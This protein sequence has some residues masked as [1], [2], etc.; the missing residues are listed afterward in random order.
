MEQE[1]IERADGISRRTVIK[2]G[3][4]VGGAIWA[5][6]AITTLSQASAEGAGGTPVCECAVL[7]Q[8]VFGGSTSNFRCEL[9]EGSC[10][11]AC[12]CEFGVGDACQCPAALV[13]QPGSCEPCGGGGAQPECPDPS[14]GGAAAVTNEVA[15]LDPVRE[16]AGDEGTVFLHSRLLDG[17]VGPLEL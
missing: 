15:S 12:F 8:V 5:A 14:P 1:T 6:P 16:V 3:A 10:R 2:R 11:C 9:T 17:P 4:I 13:I 7:V